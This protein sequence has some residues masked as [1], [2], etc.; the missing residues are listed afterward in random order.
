MKTSYRIH[1]MCIV[2][3]VLLSGCVEMLREPERT[4]ILSECVMLHTGEAT[5]IHKGDCRYFK[6]KWMLHCVNVDEYIKEKDHYY[7]YC[8]NDSLMDAISQANYARQ[9]ALNDWFAEYYFDEYKWEIYKR[10]KLLYNEA[11][12]NE[13]Q[14]VWGEGGFREATYEDRKMLREYESERFWSK[15]KR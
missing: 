2:F 4:D 12:G 7:C 13:L 6:R 1:L 15:A 11:R 5:I 9:M 10:M 8:V 3:S 14:Y